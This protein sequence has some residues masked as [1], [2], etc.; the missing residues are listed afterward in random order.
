MLSHA[1]KVNY[2]RM[3]ERIERDRKAEE[4]RKER[5]KRDP[6]LGNGK[7]MSECTTDE[8]LA[9]IQGVG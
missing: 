9:G 8:I 1:A 2:D 3:Q 4:K 7:R 6:V 5:D